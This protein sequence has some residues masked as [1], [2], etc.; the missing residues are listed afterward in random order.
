MAKTKIK[1]IFWYIKIGRLIYGALFALALS[2]TLI[3]IV[4]RGSN[5]FILL[6]LDV[7]LAFF[8]VFLESNVM[9]YRELGTVYV[10]T[11]KREDRFQ[12]VLNHANNENYFVAEFK[13]EYV[14]KLCGE[15]YNKSYKKSEV[16]LEE[17]PNIDTPVIEIITTYNISK[18]ANNEYSIFSIVGD[19][20]KIE[21]PKIIVRNKT[22]DIKKN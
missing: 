5:L 17:N 11:D 7:T 12:L 21:S 15:A 19:K 20:V 3:N 13:D 4:E 1:L 18:P 10:K 16:I 8:G 22:K 9:R 14:V 2:I 6:F